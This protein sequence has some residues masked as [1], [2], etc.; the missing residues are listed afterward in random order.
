MEQKLCFTEEGIP[1]YDQLKDVEDWD[2][3]KILEKLFGAWLLNKIASKKMSKEDVLQ[4][5]PKRVAF[6]Y[7]KRNVHAM[8][9]G[10]KLE[11]VPAKPPCGLI[12][13]KDEYLLKYGSIEGMVYVI[14]CVE[15]V[16]PRKQLPIG[17]QIKKQV[18]DKERCFMIRLYLLGMIR[19]R[20]KSILM[21]SSTEKMSMH[22]IFLSEPHTLFPT[23]F[24]SLDYLN[25]PNNENDLVDI[26]GGREESNV[27]MISNY[28]YVFHWDPPTREELAKYTIDKIALE[29]LDLLCTVSDSSR[30]FVLLPR[31]DRDR[32]EIDRLAVLF[33]CTV[34]CREKNLASWYVTAEKVLLK[35][36]LQTIADYDEIMRIIALNDINIDLDRLNKWYK[37]GDYLCDLLES[38]LESNMKYAAPFFE[39]ET[40]TMPQLLVDLTVKCIEYCAQRADFNIV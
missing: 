5:A 25:L 29:R 10:T 34:C 28:L 19:N 18:T 36:Y 40:E 23:R 13:L 12:P 8:G 4:R 7:F 33:L 37:L 11:N 39:R 27:S 1:Y 14:G 17:L 24:L 2:G 16:L 30:A 9:K 6:C 32:Y 20:H 21:G 3:S 26:G 31:L 35:K 22:G 15:K 38:R